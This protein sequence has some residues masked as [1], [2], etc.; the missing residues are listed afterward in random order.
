MIALFIDLYQNEEYNCTYF[1]QGH[2]MG[3]QLT[4]YYTNLENNKMRRYPTKVIN[5]VGGPGTEKSL[6]AAA[7]I[8]HLH[9]KGKSV[10]HVIDT[11]K[12]LVW[13]KDF[14]ML[15]NQHLVSSHQYKILKSIDGEVQFIVAEGSLPQMLYYNRTYQDNICDVEKTDKQIRK[16][17]DE[18]DNLIIFVKRDLAK[19]YVRMGREQ[20]E[21]E[22][23]DIDRR[24]ANMFKNR[25]IQ[26][27]EIEPTVKAV[28]ELM[29]SLIRQS[30][31]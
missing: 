5:V 2:F 30:Q 4:G 1:F 31:D 6:V 23:L 18:F 20:S 19:P 7:I 14:E 28:E 3:L 21:E 25:G 26:F 9:L 22:A 13:Q 17:M 10:E 16:W 29:P 11:A 15:Q 8:L 24:M 27:H 12:Q